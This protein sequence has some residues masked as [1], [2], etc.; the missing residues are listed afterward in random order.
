MVLIIEEVRKQFR[1][2]GVLEAT[3]EPDYGRVVRICTDAAQ[4]ELISLVLLA[5]LVPIIV[6]FLIRERARRVPGWHDRH[7]VSIQGCWLAGV[8]VPSDHLY[9]FTMG[10]PG[11]NVR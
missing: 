9:P 4:R 6:D 1:R 3:T 7:L 2:P 5:V 10:Q 8:S 11:L